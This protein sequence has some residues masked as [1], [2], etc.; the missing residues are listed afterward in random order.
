[1]RKLAKI[2]S[3]LALALT[4]GAPAMAQTLSPEGLWEPGN[5]ES[6]YQISYCGNG[7]DLCGLVAWIDPAHQTADNKKLLNTYLFSEIPMRGR[8]TWRGNIH[9]AGRNINGKV[10]QLSATKMSV[11]AC[12]LFWCEKVTLTRVADK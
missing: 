8:D 3:V 1:M 11:E 12:L 6:R 9:F 7:R 10:K 2:S 5:K 4:M